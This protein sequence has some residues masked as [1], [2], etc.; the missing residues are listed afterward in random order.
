MRHIISLPVRFGRYIWWSRNILRMEVRRAYLL[1]Y[2]PLA[3]RENL[4][5]RSSGS[6]GGAVFANCSC[7]YSQQGKFYN[8]SAEPNRQ[9]L[10]LP[11]PRLSAGKFGEPTTVKKMER[12]RCVGMGKDPG[13]NSV[14]WNVHTWHSGENWSLGYLGSET[15]KC[16]Q[17]FKNKWSRAIG[18]AGVAHEK[19]R[20]RL[21]KRTRRMKPAADGTGGQ[22][23]GR[24]MLPTERTFKN[25]RS[26]A[27]G[28]AVVAA[29][30]HGKSRRRLRKRTRRM[31]P[32]GDG[33]GGQYGGR[34]K[35]QTERT[36][37]NKRSGAI[38]V[39]G[40]AHG[41]SR[42]RLR[43]ESGGWNRPRRAWSEMTAS[44]RIEVTSGFV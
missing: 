33:T 18:V 5:R 24:A 4:W 32:A 27:I 23:R 37:K 30:A 36:F 22:Y 40:V 35:L 9:L 43:K 6:C 10:K 2:W 42:R 16:K 17:T 31:N 39:A 25:K 20:R 34:A 21:R 29:V 19:S 28:V 13:R 7:S 3:R 14:T 11:M 26:R 1:C 15:G 12:C 41:K 8:S 38:C 44:R